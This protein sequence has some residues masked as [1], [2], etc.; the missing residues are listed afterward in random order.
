MVFSVIYFF[1][2]S[3]KIE[4]EIQILTDE[5]NTEMSGATPDT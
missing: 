2:I 1:S 4:S 5:Q 3:A